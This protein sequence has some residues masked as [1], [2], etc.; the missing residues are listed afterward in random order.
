M[1]SV[2]DIICF[3]SVHIV[4]LLYDLPSFMVQSGGKDAGAGM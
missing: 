1:T 3:S 4:L 2:S